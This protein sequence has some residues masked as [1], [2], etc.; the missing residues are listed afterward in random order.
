MRRF[1]KI[2]VLVI[3]LLFAT[4][5]IASV[6][7]HSPNA[8]FHTFDDI[9]SLL[10]SFSLTLPSS[11]PT[12]PPSPNFQDCLNQIC[13]GIPSFTPAFNECLRECFAG[14]KSSTSS[15]TTSP[16]ST[17]PLL[18]SSLPSFSSAP[19]QSSSVPIPDDQPFCIDA[20][21]KRVTDRTSCASPTVQ[22]TVLFPSRITPTKPIDDLIAQLLGI[23]N[24]PSPQV[25][26]LP[27]PEHD[28]LT[29]LTALTTIFQRLPQFLQIMTGSPLITATAMDQAYQG[30]RD[31]RLELLSARTQCAEFYLTSGKTPCTVALRSS[32]YALGKMR[33][34]IEPILMQDIPTSAKISDLFKDL[35]AEWNT[36]NTSGPLLQPSIEVPAGQPFLE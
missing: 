7:I 8:S 18:M 15:V 25:Q 27:P 9:P 6:R 16:S 36:S 35:T 19:K 12:S 29:V 13:K 33:I 30:Y 24:V 14:K 26:P 11:Q 3:T 31:A 23:T 22:G 1:H 5:S 34:S 10:P 21:G 20:T 17:A 2:A 4:V 32:I 28:P